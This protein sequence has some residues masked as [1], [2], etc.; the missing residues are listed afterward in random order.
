[1]SVESKKITLLTKL[2]QIEEESLLNQINDLIDQ[3]QPSYYTYSGSLLTAKD[4]NNRL[5]KG[6]NEI[7]EGNFTSQSDLEKEV[8][9]W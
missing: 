8:E 1:M 7:L 6:E 2:L 5:K 3:N 9:N 4:Y